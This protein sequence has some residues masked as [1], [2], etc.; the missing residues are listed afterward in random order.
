M[1]EDMFNFFFLI[2]SIVY[3]LMK[4]K[5]MFLIAVKCNCGFNKNKLNSTLFCVTIVKLIIPLSCEHSLAVI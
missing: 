4:R 5:F 2:S 3:Y 1:L